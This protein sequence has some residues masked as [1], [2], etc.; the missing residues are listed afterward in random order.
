M[1]SMISLDKTVRNLS[2]AVLMVLVAGCAS[3][4]DKPELPFWPK[5]PDPTRYVYEGVIRNPESL[6][7]RTS[8]EIMLQG[9]SSKQGESYFVKPFDV[10]AR[11]GRLVVSDTAARL[12]H[13]FDLRQGLTYQMGIRGDGK[14]QKPVGV[15]VDS[16]GNFYVADVSAQHVVVFDGTGHFKRIIGSK[17]A[18]M[19]PTDVC[20]SADGSM[21]YVVDLGGIESNQHR[22]VVYDAAGK[23]VKT[24]GQRG[25]GDGEFNL[26]S[27]CDVSLQDGRLFVL[28]AGNFRVQVFEPDGRFVRH[29]GKVGNELGNLARPRGLA[30]D[31]EGHVYV[32]DAAFANFQVFNPEGQLLL[33][34]AGPSGV[35]VPGG[36]ALPAGI[37]VDN[38]NYVYI[39][40]Q[41]FNK[42]EVL[43]KLTQQG[44]AG[45]KK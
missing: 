7:Q 17:E 28:D 19:R 15:G 16:A 5:P 2:A 23:L 3:Q 30:V 20:A 26:P 6:K 9:V 13:L 8:T 29:W 25:G 27:Q 34:V 36:F 37:A 12:V 33:P 1:L 38:K 4:P 18:L 11:D 14:L 32:V 24:I 41:R 35:D 45:D 21:V 10:A 22:V 40:D 43:R 42:V 44:A 31:E 39:V